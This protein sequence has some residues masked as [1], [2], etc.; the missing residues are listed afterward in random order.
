MRG[1]IVIHLPRQPRR[2]LTLIRETSSNYF[3]EP[4]KY[5]EDNNGTQFLCWIDQ[6]IKYDPTTEKYI[7]TDRS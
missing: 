2:E 3:P 5:Y 7:H 1:E 6:F 4:F